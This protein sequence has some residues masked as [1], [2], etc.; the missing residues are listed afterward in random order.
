MAD[1]KDAATG[2]KR[3]QDDVEQSR[4][5]KAQKVGEKVDDKVQTT[6]DDTVTR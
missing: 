3:K 6:L 4:P 2:D 5:G 1:S